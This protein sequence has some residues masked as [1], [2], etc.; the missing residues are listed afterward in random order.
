[1]QLDE[2]PRNFFFFYSLFNYVL[3]RY[4]SLDE[5]FEDHVRRLTIVLPSVLLRAN[6]EDVL[7]FEQV[8]F[9]VFL[10]YIREWNGHIWLL[11]NMKSLLESVEELF[12]N[13]IV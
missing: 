7:H 5:V 8:H 6:R 9:R 3:R 12:L 11:H 10:S 1:M 2:Y 4:L 13:N